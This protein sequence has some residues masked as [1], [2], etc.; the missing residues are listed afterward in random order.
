MNARQRCR[1]RRQ[2]RYRDQCRIRQIRLNII[3][4][5]NAQQ[6]STEEIIDDVWRNYPDKDN[7]LI[8]FILAFKRKLCAHPSSSIDNRCLTKTYLYTVKNRYRRRRKQY[9]HSN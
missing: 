2:M 6:R 8:N 1:E 3:R 7:E 5:A 4:T 9:G